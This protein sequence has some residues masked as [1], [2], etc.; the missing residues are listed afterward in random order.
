MS[1][2][3]TAEPTTSAPSTFC[4]A[5][6]HAKTSPTPKEIASRVL[7]AASG[8]RCSGWFA[9]YD[10]RSCAWR[11]RQRSLFEDSET[12]SVDLPRAGTMRSGSLSELPTSAL[13]TSEHG[14][15]SWPTP[16]ETDSSL[17]RRHG[18]TF[19]GHSG[20]TLTDAILAFLGLQTTRQ[21]GERTEA[22]AGPN[23]AFCEALMATPRD[24]R[25]SVLG[26]AVHVGCAEVAGHVAAS[27]LTGLRSGAYSFES[28]G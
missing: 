7:E 17:G 15:S 26:N 23:P 6:F 5:D 24:W 14:S 20:T 2:S 16:T 22:P 4:A 19:E 18:Y 8:S 21:R 9:S 25:L 10:P 13:P 11:T 28:G 27:F 1:A 3:K 12:C